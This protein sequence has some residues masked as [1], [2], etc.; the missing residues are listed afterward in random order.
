MGLRLPSGLV[1]KLAGPVVTAQTR[2][3]A[4]RAEFFGARMACHGLDSIEQYF[5]E[6]RRF[7]MLPHATQITCPTLIIEADH[8]FAGGN[9]QTLCDAVTGPAELV[10]LTEAE[11]ADGHCAGLGQQVWAGAVYGWLQRALAGKAGATDVGVAG[12]D[13]EVGRTRR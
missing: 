4:D 6:L 10:R 5:S 7:N 11:G 12:P 2:I 9:G 8:D 1:G 3:S 13:V